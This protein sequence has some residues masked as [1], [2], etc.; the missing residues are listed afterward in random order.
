MRRAPPG[1]F[2]GRSLTSY[3]IGRGDVFFGSFTVTAGQQ[4]LDS[5]Q[6]AGANN[7]GIEG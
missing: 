5:I 6:S 7:R 3:V 2:T 1:G 4:D